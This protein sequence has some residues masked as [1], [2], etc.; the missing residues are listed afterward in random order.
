MDSAAAAHLR[1]LARLLVGQPPDQLLDWGVVLPM[2]RRYGLAP[3]LS[4]QLGQGSERAQVPGEVLEALKLDYYAAAAQ[5]VR[6]E[7]QLGH[8]LGALV[9]AQIPT[10]VLKGLATAAAYPHPALRVFGD[11]DIWVTRAHLDR[12]EE[13][14]GRVGYRCVSPRQEPLLHHH[15]P[16]MLS[17][18][19]GVP[20]EVHWRLDDGQ[21]Q[22]RLPE[23]DLWARATA[24]SVD[25]QATLRLERVDSVL[26]L[27]RHAVVQNL[28]HG[29]VPSLFDLVYLSAGWGRDEWGALAQ[30][31]VDYGLG[32]AVYLMLALQE[33]L[34]GLE[35]PQGVLRTLDPAPG[36]TLPSGLFERLVPVDDR[37]RRPFPSTATRAWSR[38]SLSA[39]LGYL[40]RSVFPAPKAM[41]AQSQLPTGSPRVWLMYLLRPFTLLGRYGPILWRAFRGKADARSTWELD[42]WLQQWLREENERA[43]QQVEDRPA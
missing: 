2:A 14:L 18:R 22:G 35:V 15:I 25:G 34:L 41:A 30:R 29:G 31:A 27:C 39:R 6:L 24:W 5:Y 1:T 8:V 37:P 10:I 9:A 43:L 32:R 4:F 42:L 17:S 20:L 21:R 23:Q 16:Q 12:A 13:A 26:H 19:G 7:D 33:E 3:L 40:L 38:D 36:T 11:L 28:L